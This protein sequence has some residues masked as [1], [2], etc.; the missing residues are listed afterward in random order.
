VG[1]T[2]KKTILLIPTYPPQIFRG[3]LLLKR[4]FLKNEIQKL[5]VEKS[6][7]SKIF[8]IQ[9]YSTF[10]NVFMSFLKIIENEI[11]KPFK[12]IS[13]PKES[14]NAK[15]SIDNCNLSTNI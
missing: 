1:I 9:K 3:V 13:F 4:Q 11:S 14:R 15:S 7:I 12:S 6:T 10:Y 5:I 2:Y 8:K